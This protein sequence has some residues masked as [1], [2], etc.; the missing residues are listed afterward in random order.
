M[1][2]PFYH[3]S[4]CEALT[5]NWL[6]FELLGGKAATFL[7][8][9]YSPTP[10]LF[11]KKLLQCLEHGQTIN[12]VAGVSGSIIRKLVKRESEAIRVTENNTLLLCYGHQAI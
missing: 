3:D 4:I 7:Y 1:W 6:N 11:F 10:L 12:L 9:H 2:Y 8:Y 5:Q